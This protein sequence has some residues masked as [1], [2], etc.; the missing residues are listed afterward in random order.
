[1]KK[2][3][4][5]YQKTA[6]QKLGKHYLK[7][8]KG[9]L[10][11]PTGGGK[12]FTAVKFVSA[13]FGSKQWD[14]DSTLVIWLSHTIELIKQTKDAFETEFGKER[15]AVIS[16][17]TGHD[18]WE[19][20]NQKQEYK[21]KN[22]VFA[23]YLS[24]S[25][26]TKRKGKNRKD[27]SLDEM[28]EFIK[29]SKAKNV[30]LVIDEAHRATA[31]T[32]RNI[33]EGLNDLKKQKNNLD[34]V[35]LLG[36]T[37]TPIRMSQME[38][39]TLHH[40]F[41]SNKIYEISTVELQKQGVLSKLYTKSIPTGDDE[42][43]LFKT[44]YDALKSKLDKGK[45]LN[46]DMLSKIGESLTRNQLIVNHYVKNRDTYGPTIVFATSINH[47]ET[48]VERFKK[49]VS[50][51]AIHSKIDENARVHVL[52]DFKA[53]NLDVLVN[54]NML[55][56]GVDLPNAKTAFLTRPTNSE[57][58][59]RQMVGRVLRG[60]S[61][62]G[63]EIAYAVDFEDA[64]DKFSPIS[65]G[66]LFNGE[67]HELEDKEYNSLPLKETI[68]IE[69]ILEISRLIKQKE[70][71]DSTNYT[72]MNYYSWKT[73]EE[74]EILNNSLITYDNWDYALQCAIDKIKS[75]PETEINALFL[76]NEL[77][78]C[79]GPIPRNERD[80][81]PVLELLEIIQNDGD[82]EVYA[83]DEITQWSPS[84]ILKKIGGKNPRNCNSELNNIYQESDYLKDQYKDEDD[85]FDRVFQ[86]YRSSKNKI[87]FNPDYKQWDKSNED[88]EINAVYER[89]LKSNIENSG[90]FE[91]SSN[92]LKRLN[93][94]RYSSA[95]KL[96][97][98]WGFCQEEPYF[99][100]KINVVLCPRLNAP[101]IPLM[102]L[103]FIMYHELV[104][105]EQGYDE[106]H[107]PEFKKWEKM[108]K[109]TIK[110]INDLRNNFPQYN[111]KLSPRYS[112]YDLCRH[113]QYNLN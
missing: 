98:A 49:E 64:W 81:I 95:P 6:I 4:R 100:E 22:L 30:F 86:E 78:D 69:I 16:S 29:K 88:Y 57:A 50:C 94:P 31:K 37:A 18:K 93:P 84:S 91:I 75:K 60:E 111:K 113:L 63:T 87:I 36:L 7:N 61:S 24:C 17:Q 12:T 106:G 99:D 41:D 20:L 40:L 112:F 15:I 8:D 67:E 71:L 62:K 65:A 19:N 10:I 90:K 92:K 42:S 103:E 66:Y 43:S 110:A 45:N 48:L 11:L 80:F 76:N 21:S 34:K 73:E 68:P 107:G 96:P 109:P 28:K 32:Y 108:F 102:F 1:M 51:E 59:L 13:M 52:N 9:M 35:K 54:V 85:F 104:H 72:P 39:E 70:L 26:L 25:K 47:C 79:E 101:D 53:G 27:H 74:G 3:L 83:L 97:S 33:L 14:E 2:E 38:Q 82:Y 58:L 5:D 55:T 77:R 56:E 89:V 44:D 23:S 46:Q 105:V